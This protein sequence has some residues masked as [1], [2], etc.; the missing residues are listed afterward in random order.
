MLAID[1]IGFGDDPSQHLEVSLGDHPC[2]LVSVND[3]RV[4]CITGSTTQTHHINNN[5]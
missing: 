1:G 3:T 4:I 5:A 2:Q